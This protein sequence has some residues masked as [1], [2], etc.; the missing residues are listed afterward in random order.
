MDGYLVEKDE[1]ILRTDKDF[2]AAQ[3]MICEGSPIYD[4]EFNNK[5][6]SSNE[7]NLPEYYQ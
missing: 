5:S 2:L 4:Y 3:Q 1:M 7:K 6:E